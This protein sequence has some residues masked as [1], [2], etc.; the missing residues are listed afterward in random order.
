MNKFSVKQLLNGALPTD[1]TVEISGWVR[2]RR[3]S[4]AGLSFIALSDGS[5]FATLQIVAGNNLENYTSDIIR[6]TKDCSIKATGKIVASLGGGQ[7]IEILADKIE[8]IGWVENPDTYPVSPKRHTVEYLREVAHLRVRTNL[9]AA[10]TRVRNTVCF[11]IHEYLQQNG[12]NWIHTPIITSTDC[13]GAGELFNVTLFDIN[14]PPRD[15]KGNI[16]YKQDFFGRQTYLT[17]SGQLNVEAYCMALSKVY[18]FG[19]TFR[20]ENSNTTRHLAEFW[21]VEPEIAFAN[22]M[23]NANLATDLLKHIFK[24]VLNRNSDDMRFFAEFVDKNVIDRLEQIVNGSF[25]MINYTEA[26][27]YLEKANKKFDNPVSWGIDLA[28]EHERWLCEEHIGQPTIVTDY[29]KDF[30][31]FYMRQNEDGK[32]VAAMDILAPGI[33]EIVGGSVREERYD[34]LVK[35]MR[36]MYLSEEQLHWYLDLRRFGSAPHAGFGLGLDRLI[37]YITGISNIRD[38]IPFPRYPKSANF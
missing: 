21:M 14:R 5:C 1:E 9:I 10:A 18:T 11:S 27:N 37:N 31:A 4:K 22:L 28:S 23:D 7:S 2:S 13:E 24:S 33:G 32:T 35:R 3:D 34:M 15:E 16:D 20:A 8:V 19:P 25:A 6:I 30:K 17:V 12:F 36:E 26:I 29:P 38:I